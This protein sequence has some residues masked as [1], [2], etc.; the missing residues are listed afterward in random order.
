MQAGDNLVLLMLILICIIGSFYGLR[1]LFRTSESPKWTLNADDEIPISEAVALLEDTGYEVMT[2]KR[3]VPITILIDDEEELQSRL[4]IDHFAKK[5]NEWYLVK[6]AR[7]R[8]VLEM[9]GSSIRD[10]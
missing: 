4:F 8:K 10:Y 3:K 5:G 6:I 9:T 1:R 7:P 2:V